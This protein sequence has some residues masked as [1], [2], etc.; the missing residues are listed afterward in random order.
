[1]IVFQFRHSRA[2]GD[3]GRTSSDRLR[4]RS[5]PTGN[6]VNVG[7]RWACTN[8]GNCFRYART[9]KVKL[10]RVFAQTQLDE[11]QRPVRDELTTSY[12]GA[13]ESAEAFG[14]RIYAE[15]IRPGVTRSAQAIVLGDGA[16]WIWG[17][18]EEHF[19]ARFRSSISSTRGS[20]WLFCQPCL[21]NRCDK[22]ERMDRGPP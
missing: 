10:G 17:I 2:N 3:P 5:A 14:T 7:A 15:A 16:R 20:T 6:Y 18:A 13:M 19:T 21:W 9:R 1:M 8:G 4:L 12:V 22:V 11:H